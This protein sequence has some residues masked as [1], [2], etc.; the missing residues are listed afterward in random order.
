[1]RNVRSGHLLISRL[2]GSAI[3]LFLASFLACLAL[4][5]LVSVLVSTEVSLALIRWLLPLF[6]KGALILFCGT[7]IV[8]LLESI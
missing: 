8:S 1:M 5:F 6:G 3:K 7:A 4:C 2:L